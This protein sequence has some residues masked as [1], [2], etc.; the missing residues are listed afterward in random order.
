MLQKLIK[1]MEKLSS[2]ER[3]EH[4]G[5]FFKTGK[6]EYGEGDVFLGLTMPEQRKFAKKYRELSLSNLQ[7]LLDSKI[8]EHRMIAGII[9]TEKYKKNPEEIFN[10]YLKN[11]KRFNN[12]D[13]VDAT[14]PK[15]VGNFL[16]DKNKK[17]LYGLANSKNLW[18]K[19]IAIVSTYSFI[20][21]NQFADTLKISEILLND[22]RDLIHKAVGWMLR[23]VGKKN[24]DV[25]KDF[26]KINYK[27]LPRTTL[28]YAIER[29]SKGE[30]KKY[31]KGEIK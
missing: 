4:S 2:K 20:I 10:F 29:F 8:H 31:L 30:R 19:R 3:V 28:R 17:I 26:L 5:R 25:L 13:L 1:E 22:K 21:E 12:W 11:A 24:V 16:K 18:E 23:E 9:L 15:I 7:R 6:G 27:K 14:C